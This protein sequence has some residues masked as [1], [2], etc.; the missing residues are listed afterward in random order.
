MI[1]SES[2]ALQCGVL[3]QRMTNSRLSCSSADQ[4]CAKPLHMD[5]VKQELYEE[6]C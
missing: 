4:N 1:A 3:R 5:V 2:L 6:L